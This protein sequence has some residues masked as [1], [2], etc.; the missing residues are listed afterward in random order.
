[1]KRPLLILL[2]FLISICSCDYQAHTQEPVWE[3]QYT[4]YNIWKHHEKRHMRFINYKSGYDII[5][6]GTAVYDIEPREEYP[7]A[8]RF[9]IVESGEQVEI[10][11]TKRWHPGKTVIDHARYLFTS[12]N[13][14]Q[15]TEDFNPDEIEA[16]KQG[17]VVEGMRKKAVIMSYGIPPE[18]KTPNLR[19]KEWI[20][21]INSR[22]QKRICFDMEDKT[23]SCR[24][25]L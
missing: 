11:F 19:S 15:L 6:A 17:I 8:I 2:V 13:F 7:Y 9:K 21:W 23:I 10:R 18:H 22:K 5:P 12:K 4:A 24:D 3:K 1:M 16:I 14:H 20:Y 25:I